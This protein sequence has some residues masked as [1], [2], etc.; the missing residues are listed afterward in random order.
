VVKIVVTPE[1]PADGGRLADEVLSAV[2]NGG[3]DGSQPRDA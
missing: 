1:R 2:R 3:G